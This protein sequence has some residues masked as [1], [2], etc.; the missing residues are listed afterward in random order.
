MVRDRVR[1]VLH[2]LLEL[3]RRWQLTPPRLHLAYGHVALLL[4]LVLLAP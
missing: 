1:A 4:D 3:V 2:Q